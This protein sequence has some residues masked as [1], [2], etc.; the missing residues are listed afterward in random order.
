MQRFNQITT[1]FFHLKT[2]VSGVRVIAQKM[3]P[4]WVLPPLSVKIW[5]VGREP[6]NGARRWLEKD[7]I[8]RR[9]RQPISPRHELWACEKGGDGGRLCNGAPRG[10]GRR[11]RAEP[12]KKMPQKTNAEN[13]GGILIH[14]HVLI[15]LV[16][17]NIFQ[18]NRSR[19]ISPPLKYKITSVSNSD[20]PSLLQ[21]L[22]SSRKSYKTDGRIDGSDRRAAQKGSR[23]IPAS[24][25][26]IF[27]LSLPW[28]PSQFLLRTTFQSAPV[29]D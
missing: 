7:E 11:V 29:I 17:W 21:C 24:V 22:S 2:T 26:V 4:S 1:L 3:L 19:H 9:E 12:G 27:F 8:C 20:F 13:R 28:P 15:S 23:A 14:G 16:W 5:I 18:K 6:R 10:R 25:S